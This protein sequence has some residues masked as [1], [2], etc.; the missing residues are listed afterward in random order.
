MCFMIPLVGEEKKGEIYMCLNM[1]R[2]FLRKKQ[3]T[4]NAYFWKVGNGKKDQ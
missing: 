3:V 2:K 1:I 4:Y